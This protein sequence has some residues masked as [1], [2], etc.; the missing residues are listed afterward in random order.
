M[1]KRLDG[2]HRIDADLFP[3]PGNPE[4]AEVPIAIVQLGSAVPARHLPEWELEARSLYVKR[5]D[6]E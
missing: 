3:V 6:I 1:L 5:G 4:E 2:V